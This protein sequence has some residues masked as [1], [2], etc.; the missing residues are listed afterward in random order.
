[1]GYAIFAARKIMLTS[2][3]NNLNWRIMCLSQQQQS[4][5]D[6]SGRMQQYFGTMSM[7]MGN[8]N[9]SIWQA[10]GLGN[11]WNGGNGLG[12]GTIAQNGMNFMNSM[13]YEQMMLNMQ[14][15]MM[16]KPVADQENQI[17]LERKRL[18]TQLQAATKEL[19]KVEQAEEKQI[20]SSAPKYA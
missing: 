10:M 8:Q 3:I 11:Q 13:S 14:S 2:R 19:E 1:M 9:A 20:E 16:L 7:L 17:E 6:V 5:S 12:S 18:E 15:Q 4:L